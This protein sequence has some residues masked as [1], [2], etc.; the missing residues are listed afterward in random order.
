MRV[1]HGRY[2]ER[3]RSQIGKKGNVRAFGLT[4]GGLEASRRAKIVTVAALRSGSQ[5]CT[6]TTAGH[7][8]RA[9]ETFGRSRPTRMQI[10]IIK[11][12]EGRDKCVTCFPGV[13]S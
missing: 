8:L 11:L 12:D 5:V 7:S 9:N 10:Y 2:M 1:R 3:K 6:T 4:M 13:L